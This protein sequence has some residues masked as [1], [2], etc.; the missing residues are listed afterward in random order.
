MKEKNEWA[1]P[2]SFS[3]VFRCTSQKYAE[4]LL[5]KGE[6]KFSTPS[7]W[8]KYAIEKGEGRGDKLEGTIATFNAFDI[9]QLIRLNQKYSKYSDLV[10]MSIGKRVYLKRSRDL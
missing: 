2:E 6:I 3:A 8:V 10:R 1:E 5:K 4:T 9:D 7:S